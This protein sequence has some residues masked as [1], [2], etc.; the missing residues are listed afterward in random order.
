MQPVAALQN[1]YSLWFRE[2][3]TTVMPVLDELGIADR[4]HWVETKMGYWYRGMLQPWGNPVA[5]LK[6]RG[7]GP[8]ASASS[9]SSRC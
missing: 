4:M 8:I 6:F 1:E 9:R 3:E 7:L 5:L 2:P